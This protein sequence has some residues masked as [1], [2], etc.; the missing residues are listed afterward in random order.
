MTD[1]DDM[2]M[3]DAALL[4]AATDLIGRTG[5]KNLTFGHLNDDPPHRWWAKAQYT[6]AAITVE[7]Q[8]GP[9]EALT[10][11]CEKVMTGGQCQLCGGLIALSDHGAVAYEG[12]FTNGRRWTMDDITAAGQCRWNIVGE[13]WESGCVIPPEGDDEIHTAEKLARALAA[14][15]DPEH[16]REIM[17]RARRGHY[18]DWRS[19]L[20][21]PMIQLVDDLRAAGHESMAQRVALGE[22]DSSRAESS[23]WAASQEGQELF[24]QLTDDL[25]RQRK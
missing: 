16:L 24:A 21:F 23:A 20:S 3:P 5:A 15:N 1:V 6:G 9:D 12:M 18:H 7:D 22:F 4:R 19:S 17:W 8:A 11:L 13:R 10:A 2:S 25:R 14:L